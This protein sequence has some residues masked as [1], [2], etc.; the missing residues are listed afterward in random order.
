M[1]Y[2]R[3]AIEADPESALARSRLAGALLYLGDLEEAEE[4]ASRD[5]GLGVEIRGSATRGHV[6][7]S[8]ASLE[9]L[10]LVLARLAGK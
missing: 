5:I 6:R 3:Q 10:E 2:Y 4:Q 7:I 8:Y 1:Y 9:Q